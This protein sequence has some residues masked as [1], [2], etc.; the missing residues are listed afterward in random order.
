VVGERER[1]RSGSLR[2]DVLALNG[3]LGG[4]EAQAN[5]LVP[6]PATLARTG[7]LDLG[8]A[9]E[10]DCEVAVVS[11]RPFANS[12]AA[13]GC[14]PESRKNSLCGCFWKARSL[15]TVSSV[16]ILS[17]GRGPRLLVEGL[18]SMVGSQIQFC[19]TRG[20][21]WWQKKW[22]AK[23]DVGHVI[24]TPNWY[25]SRAGKTA[26]GPLECSPKTFL[27][28]S[29]QSKGLPLRNSSSSIFRI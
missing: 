16:A 4:A 29:T 11:F 25:P 26:P 21:F 17:V 24:S 8:L 14:S 15:W 27:C 18:L 28:N 13:V 12:P 19:L 10:E 7:R 20:R 3:A 9:V 22:C 23:M 6:S 5:V 2:T 1:H